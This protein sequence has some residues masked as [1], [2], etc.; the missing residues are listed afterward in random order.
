LAVRTYPIGIL[1]MLLGGQVIG[2]GCRL[3]H[4]T[5]PVEKTLLASRQLSRQA[6]AALGQQQWDQ[7][8]AFS[9]QAVHTCPADLDARQ[10]Y[11]EALWAKGQRQ[12]ALRQLEEVSRLAS[13]DAAIPARM[14]EMQLAMGQIHLARQYANRAIE[15]N[16]QLPDAWVVRAR[17]AQQVGDFR[18]ALADYHRAL[19]Y[20]PNQPEVL[21]EIAE[22]YR[23]ANQPDRALA[24][25]HRLAD[26]YSPGEEPPQ[27]FYL[28]GLAYLALNR[29]Q[30]AVE[31]LSLAIQRGGPSAEWLYQLA[32][33]EAATGRLRRAQQTLQHALALDPNHAPS[34]ELFSQLESVQPVQALLPR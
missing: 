20:A 22:V 9:E 15:L 21:L 16:P 5:Q 7:A 12:E 27:I 24:T 14:A 6:V 17:V 31:A 23:A 4:P 28:Q 8:L 34:R 1:L 30:D 25:L 26:T 2:Q 13:E 19:S 18:S 3:L 29:P 32:Q 11:A 10:V 33:A